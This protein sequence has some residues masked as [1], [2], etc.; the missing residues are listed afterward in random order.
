LI[1]LYAFASD[2]AALP[3]VTGVQGE[4]LERYDFA[5][6]SAVISRTVTPPEPDRAEVVAHGL[7]V[8]ALNELAESVLPVRFGEAFAD[9]ETFAAA[10]RRRLPDLR[11]RLERLRGCVEVGVRVSVE[12]KLEKPAAL[13]ESGLAYMRARLSAVSEHDAVVGTLRSRLERLSLAA[14]GPV[15]SGAYLVRRTDV[16][17]VQDDV[18]RFASAHPDLTVLCTGPWAPYS[19]SGGVGGP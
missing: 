1:H 13:D 14:A 6:V 9:D 19:F 7:V 16:A 4:S 8:E 11:G 18:E 12:P 17:T 10:V 15:E 3:E 2:L 5:D